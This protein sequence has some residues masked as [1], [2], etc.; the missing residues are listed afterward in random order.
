LGAKLY[1]K[2]KSEQ[3]KSKFFAEGDEKKHTYEFTLSHGNAVAI[4]LYHWL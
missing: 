3:I 2:S 4:G 1:K